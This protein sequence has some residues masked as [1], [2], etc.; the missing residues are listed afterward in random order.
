MHLTHTVTMIA[1]LLPALTIFASSPA[2][3]EPSSRSTAASEVTGVGLTLAQ[4]TEHDRILI[5][6]VP[7]G[8]PAYKANIRPGDILFAVNGN[9]VNARSFADVAKQIR[10]PV[11]TVVTVTIGHGKERRDVKLTRVKITVPRGDGVCTKKENFQIPLGDDAP[12]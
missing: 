10:G 3:T 8:T 2:K 9:S 11:G 5:A 12:N 6:G 7:K 1:L 4:D